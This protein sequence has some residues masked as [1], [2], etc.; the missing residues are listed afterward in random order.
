MGERDQNIT[1]RDHSKI[2]M[3]RFPWVHKEGW[4]AGT[5]EGGR[6]LSA[7]MP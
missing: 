4:G 3:P 1:A 6:N 7:Y 5:G 2:T